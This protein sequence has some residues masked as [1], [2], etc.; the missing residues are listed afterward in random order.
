LETQ[1]DHCPS[2]QHC[3]LGLEDSVTDV[4]AAH[5]GREK[6][7]HPGAV[8]RAVAVTIDAPEGVNV[9]N[10]QELAENAWRYIAKEIKIGEVTV[11]V[12]AFSR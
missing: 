2:E 5:R 11:K 1:K 6:G 8:E 4:T 7:W 10:L 12:R 9:V 3:G